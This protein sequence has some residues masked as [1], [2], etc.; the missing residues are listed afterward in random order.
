MPSHLLPA[1]L[2]YRLLCLEVSVDHS[3]RRLGQELCCPP[4]VAVAPPLL[5]E[6]TTWNVKAV[7][8]PLQTPHSP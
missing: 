5:Q 7:Q 8:A 2:I 4:A 6:E 3:L 1:G